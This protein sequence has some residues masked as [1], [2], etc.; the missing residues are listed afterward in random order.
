MTVDTDRDTEVE[1]LR[2]EVA[3]LMREVDRYRTATEEAMQLVDWCI[4]Y[5][6]GAN[7]G[8]IA[9][10]LGDNRTHIRQHLLRRPDDNGMPSSPAETSTTRRA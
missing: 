5:F 7:K 2:G 1:Q 3:R 8:S 4:G 10:P 9:K 6:V